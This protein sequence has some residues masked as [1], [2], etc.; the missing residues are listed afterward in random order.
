MVVGVGEKA[1]AHLPGRRE[2]DNVVVSISN[3]EAG[4]LQNRQRKERDEHDR[5]GVKC[6]AVVSRSVGREQAA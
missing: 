2:E 6:T 4:P 1:V 3:L 5:E